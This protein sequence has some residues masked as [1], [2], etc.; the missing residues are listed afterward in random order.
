MFKQESSSALSPM[1]QSSSCLDPL[2]ID[3]YIDF[4]QAIHPSPS[5]TTSSSP[6]PSSR[7]KAIAIP[8]FATGIPNNTLHPP[9]SSSQPIFAGPSHQY[10]LHKQQTGIPV[11]AL[12]ST[13]A[14]N[15]PNAFPFGGYQIQQDY[16]ATPVTDGYFGMNTVVDD[17]FDFNTLP[18]HN[19]SFGT[20]VDT[21]M[22]FDSPTQDFFSLNNDTQS[23]DNDFIDPNA[24]GGREDVSASSTPIQSNVGRLWPGMHQQQAAQAAMAKA[25]AEQRQQSQQRVLQQRQSVAPPQPRQPAT[26]P[27]ASS[28]RPPTDPIVEERISRLL[29]QMR[30]NSEA[31]SHEDPSTPTGSGLPHLARQRKEEEDMDEDE[32]LLASEEGKKLSSKER[33]QLRN[34]VSAR[35]FRSRRKGTVVASWLPG[36][37]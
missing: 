9:Q 18:S 5:N 22:D 27:A 28:S 24:I 29:N 37:S 26:R 35:A 13:L 23:T 34:K 31:T 12:S 3:R 30:Q 11:G 6:S 25:Q 10:E 2:D 14:V 15:Q 17:M 33:R 1:A 21:D 20:S 36:N 19:P 7:G 8:E 4:D 16:G 32:R